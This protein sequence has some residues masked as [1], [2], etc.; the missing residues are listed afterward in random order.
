MKVLR[1]LALLLAALSFFACKTAQKQVG[2]DGYIEIQFLQMN[3]VYEISP[4]PSDNTGGLARVAMIRRE[5]LAKNPNTYTVLAGDFISP[6]V[7]GTLRHEGKRIRGKQMVEVLNT[8]GLDWVVFGNHEFDYDDVADLQARIDE[9][10][11]LWVGSNVFQV[12]NGNTKHFEK[13]KAGSIEGC[14]ATHIFEVRDADGTSLRLGLFGV[15]INTGIKPYVAYTDYFEASNNS[16]AALK[17][18]HAEQGKGADVVV[19][20]THLN[21]EDDKKLSAILPDM[22]LIM[23]GHEHD[24]QIHKVGKATIAKADANAKTVYVHTLRYDKKN[25]SATVKSELRRVDASIADDPATAAVVAKWEKIKNESLQSSGF[26]PAAIVTVLPEPLDCRETIVRHTQC[27]AGEL[28][29]AAMMAASKTNPECALLNSGS[30]R[31]DDVLAPT[32][33]EVDIVRMLPFGGG[34]T[35]VEMRGSLLRRT[36][37]AS[38]E[39]KGKGGYLQLRNIRQGETGRWLVS[40]TPLDDTR[41]YRVVLPDFLLTGGEYRMEFLKASPDADGKAGANPDILSFHKPLPG[42][43]NDARTDIR[44]AVIR[45]LKGF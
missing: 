7:I 41:I 45:Y 33:T 1:T 27:R 15:T 16:F 20:L 8:L 19:A 14:G 2:D 22:P 32:L 26:Q 12:E 31:V 38:L 23:G 17:N 44:W 24:N 35:E 36:L 42:D 4:A 13:H 28:I 40:E 29:T 9:S 21:I 43:K 37:E 25:K 6:S 34:I 5:L 39:N 30:I 10:A 18:L 11:F 3:D